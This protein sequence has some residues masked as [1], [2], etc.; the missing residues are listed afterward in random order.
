[1]KNIK[2]LKMDHIQFKTDEEINITN[3]QVII[4]N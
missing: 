4:K 3:N 2:N 1:M